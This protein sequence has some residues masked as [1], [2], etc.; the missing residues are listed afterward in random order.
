MR[1]SAL[2]LVLLAGAA[3]ADLPPLETADLGDAGVSI[4]TYNF[5]QADEA[6]YLR[7]LMTRPSALIEGWMPVTGHGALAVAPEEGL[8]R[9]GARVPSAVAAGG[10]ASA[11]AAATAARAGCDALRQTGQGC[12]V[13]L[14]V[15]PK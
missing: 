8:W 2:A 3:R 6:D 9:A 4:W 15:A 14:Q 10:M 5:L 1:R 13:V 12:I 7:L 11:E